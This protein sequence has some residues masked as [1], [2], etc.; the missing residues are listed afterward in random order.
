MTIVGTL[1]RK[2]MKEKAG[3]KYGFRVSIV[4]AGSHSDI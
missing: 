3:Q 2:R 1:E 4:S